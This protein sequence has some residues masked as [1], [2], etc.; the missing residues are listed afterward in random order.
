MRH[1]S[2]RERELKRFVIRT[3]KNLHSPSRCVRQT[4]FFGTPGEMRRHGAR[5]GSCEPQP[6]YPVFSPFTDVE[7]SL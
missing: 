7:T 5:M 2:K 6:A 4:Q 3:T 1:A